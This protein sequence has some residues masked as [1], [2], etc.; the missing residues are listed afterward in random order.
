MIVQIFGKKYLYCLGTLENSLTAAKNRRM[1]GSALIDFQVT[2]FKL[3]E[4]ATELDAAR[5]LVYRSAWMAD[6]MKVDSRKES[7]MAKYYACETAQKV[8]DEAV[9]L[10]GGL[11]IVKR[12]RVEFLYRAIRALRMVEGTTEIQ[13]LTIARQIL[14]EHG[15][16]LRP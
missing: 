2:Q 8:I 1:F 15:I 3:A 12:Q 11:G 9:Q 6:H 14:K 10:Y 4:M 7:S 13:K 5:L 16:A